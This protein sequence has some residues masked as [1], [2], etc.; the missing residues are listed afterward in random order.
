MASGNFLFRKINN[1][2]IRKYKKSFPIRTIPSVP[3]LHRIGLSKE[4]F[5]DYTIGRDFHPAPKTIQFFFLFTVSYWR[6]FVN[7][8]FSDFGL[9][10]FFF[11]VLCY[12]RRMLLLE[13]CE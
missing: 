13:A 7:R 9:L 10:V 12:N 2:P 6:I 11:N 5:M 8:I 3:E 4:R 1:L